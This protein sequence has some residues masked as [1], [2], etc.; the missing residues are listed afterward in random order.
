MEMQFPVNRGASKSK[1]Q[2]VNRSK[3]P[4][5]VRSVRSLP[6]VLGMAVCWLWPRA[7]VPMQAAAVAEVN[8]FLGTSIHPTS[9]EANAG[10]MIPAAVTP[11]GLVQWGPDTDT[12]NPSGYRYDNTTIKGFSLTHFSGRGIGYLM[13]FPFMPVLGNVTRSPVANPG[14]FKTG[15]SHT[16]ESAS[17]GYYQVRLNNNTNVQLTATRRAGFGQFTFPAQSAVSLIIHNKCFYKPS[18]A[19]ITIDPLNRVISGMHRGQITGGGASNPYNLYFWVQF[20]RP[21]TTNGTWSGT[22][23]KA[24][25]TSSTSLSGGAYVTF[26]ARN[27]QVVKVKVGLSYVSIANAR[28]NLQ[29]EIPGWDFTAVRAAASNQWESRLSAVQVTGGM[30]DERTQFYTALY[31]SMIH[32]NVMSDVN[33]DYRGFDGVVRR[34]PADEEHFT[35]IPS[36]DQ[37]RTH[38][39]LLTLIAPREARETI[40][41]LIRDAQQGGTAPGTWPRWVQGYADSH[42]MEGDPASVMV[43]MAYAMGIRDFDT[44][45]AKAIMLNTATNPN[46]LILN[47]RGREG[48]RDYLRYGY[49]TTSGQDGGD[50]WS[51]ETLE[52]AVSD[53]GLAQFALALGDTATH[54]T[55]LARSQG[56][57]QLYDPEVDRA[58]NRDVAGQFARTAATNG[59]GFAE[60][61]ASQYTWMVPHNFKGLAAVMGGNANAVAKLDAH[62]TFLNG[63]GPGDSA[64]LGNEPDLWKPY[65]YLF[66]RTPWRTQDTVRRIRDALYANRPQGLP[67]NDDAGSMSAAYVF[68]SLGLCPLIPGVGGFLIGSP[69]F[70]EVT[71]TV[72]SGSLAAGHSL[73]VIAANAGASRPYIQ[74]ATLDG[75][76]TTSL[77]V[78]V[79]RLFSNATTTVTFD[80]GSD[81][82]TSW[83]NG[84]AD[85]PPTDQP[86]LSAPSA[87]VGLRGRARSGCKVELFW[88]DT[89]WN[90]D[91][92]KVQRSTDG[93]TFSTVATLAMN[94]GYYT[95]TA[96]AA[97]IY[98]YRV[99]ATNDS[100]DSA[101]SQAIALTAAE[102]TDLTLRDGLAAYWNFDE[103]S[104]SVADD[105][106]NG[107][108]AGVQG[109]SWTATARNGQALSFNGTN[110]YLQAGSSDILNVPGEQFTLAAWIRPAA[111]PADRSPRLLQK[112]GTGDQYRLVV[113]GGSLK[114]SLGFV[115]EV[116]APTLPAA[117]AWTH[118]AGTYDGSTLRLYFNGTQVASSA[119]SGRLH[120][121]VAPL[122]IGTLTELKPS[123]CFS[124]ILDDVRIYD[125]A[126]SAAQV[127]DV[128][129]DF[130]GV[131]PDTAGPRVSSHA[132][133]DIVPGAQS[134]LTFTF[135]EAMNTNSFALAE[136]ASFSGPGGDLTASLTN[137][138]WLDDTRLLVQFAAQSA[139]G[140]YTMVV[141]P[142]I[143]DLAGN[144]M[145]QDGNGTNGESPADRYTAAFTITAGPLPD[146]PV[147][148]YRFDEAPG[149][150]T[151]TDSSGRNHHG[152]VAGGPTFEPVGGVLGGAVTFDGTN[153]CV[154][155]GTNADFD[156]TTFSISG[157]FKTQNTNAHF[158][159]VTKGPAYN[160]RNYTVVVDKDQ[161]FALTFKFSGTTG[162][163]F[164]MS[165]AARALND[166]RWH[167]FVAVAD[168]AANAARIYL[169]GSL[170]ATAPFT[171]NPEIRPADPLYI[172]RYANSYSPGTLDDFRL[173]NR[174]LSSAEV[175][176]LY[177]AGNITRLA[178]SLGPSIEVLSATP[179]LYGLGT[180]WRASQEVGGS[181]G[182]LGFA[183]DT[184]AV[185]FGS[186]PKNAASIPSVPAIARNAAT[187]DVT[188]TFATENGRTYLVQYCDDLPTG[189]WQ[190]LATVAATGPTASYLDTTAGSVPRRFYRI[191]TQFP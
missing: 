73:H 109:A 164:S 47:R 111:W 183:T 55:F 80:M 34:L 140:A 40:R 115:G 161:A 59:R 141:G 17:P 72:P 131:P 88:Q 21:F 38:F 130:T 188:L 15:F 124:G 27:V 185:A 63:E 133:S 39:P 30:A 77:W 65:A 137:F 177:G 125:R 165:S 8:P 45:A 82:N 179:A 75:T 186:D 56:W 16:N 162:E 54:A 41:S 79:D 10:E 99:V 122:Y 23:L 163:D 81:P 176:A 173:Y 42:S 182:Y 135:N 20:D 97:G 150:A 106:A 159:V 91:G 25:S 13:D 22:T 26:D 12:S 90:E 2:S 6:Y 107:N 105:S 136:V 70:P 58:Q 85:E 46:A 134:S 155:A 60:G 184:I 98:Y 153:D 33:G 119:G 67:G 158:F 178:G 68:Y 66:L 53:F 86:S 37:Y 32:P 96:P 14:A 147:L 180:N 138:N 43:A 71:L 94:R 142:H 167:H 146:D 87:P 35:H 143:L 78:P 152:T 190:T 170:N 169:D 29:S 44:N 175:A 126:L 171:F 3:I 132:P 103:G 127:T 93:T 31:H 11:F 92:H 57:R 151:V 52:Y 49:V 18:V 61:T 62:F 9:N 19:S 123:T 76:P 156:L 50:R 5:G 84:E 101:P 1:F 129:N 172:A 117:S 48:L 149:A 4:R 100:G 110:S 189:A 28:T 116:T 89:A 157:W 104:G 83:G 168:N 181:P 108:N 24:R 64:Y 145:D 95:D 102:T 113:E 112:S 128:M 144:A 7:V 191:R 51:S 187:G 120:S 121:T 69:L 118:L 139:S 174:V 114:F 36:W 154:S 74:S 148:W 166:G 160:N